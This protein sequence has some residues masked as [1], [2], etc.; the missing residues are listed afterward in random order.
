MNKTECDDEIL[1][2]YTTKSVQKFLPKFKDNQVQHT[3]MKLQN[4]VILVGTTGSGKTNCLC[5]YIQRTAVNGKP[6]FQHMILVYKVDEPLYRTLQEQLGDNITCYRS[7][8]DLPPVQMFPESGEKNPMQLLLVF[9]DCVNDVSRDDLKKMDD[10]YA[11][12]RKHGFT[13][14]FLSQSYFA[15]HKFLRLQSSYVILNSI[16]DK[17]DLRLILK[18]YN[19]G[20]DVDTAE[21]MYRYAKEKRSPDDIPFLKINAR[22][23]CPIEK[24]FSRNFRTFLNPED[25]V[26]VK[27]G[28]K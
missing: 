24:K 8:K 1:N 7:I 16:S 6:T 25:F 22:G 2:C 12:G 18:T 14:F 20:V 19:V 21:L 4:H 17:R 10:Y 13:I 3:D 26:V 28:K 11:F 5:N 9:D 27:K 23:D 15:T